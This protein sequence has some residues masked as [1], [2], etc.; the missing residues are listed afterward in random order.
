M[1]TLPGENAIRVYAAPDYCYRLVVFRHP[2]D[3]EVFFVVQALT[4]EFR[5]VWVNSSDVYESLDVLDINYEFWQDI[6]DYFQ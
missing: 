6:T 3:H 2:D 5:F 1:Q 4:P